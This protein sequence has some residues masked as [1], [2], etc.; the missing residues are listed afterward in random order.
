MWLFQ[1]WRI[2]LWILKFSDLF[3]CCINNFLYLSFFIIIIG[4]KTESTIR[5]SKGAIV[6]LLASLDIVCIFDCCSPYIEL[7]CR[8]FFFLSSLS[9]RFFSCIVVHTQ[10]SKPKRLEYISLK[11]KAHQ[12]TK[13]TSIVHDTS[14]W[15][16]IFPITGLLPL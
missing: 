13:R 15:E 7:S 6:L 4:I 10:N 3:N 9:C 8:F 12:K 1:I 16:F 2:F 14:T 5:R 11:T